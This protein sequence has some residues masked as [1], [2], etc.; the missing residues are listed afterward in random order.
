MVNK[1]VLVVGGGA[2]GLMAAITAAGEGAAVT[3][4]EQ[5]E[6]PGKK[7]CATGNGR[8]NLTNLE[9]PED[10]YRGNHPRFV[11]D[12]LAF[13]SVQ[14]TI[15]F[16]T[17]IGIYPTN[18]NGYLYPHSGQAQSVVDVLCMEASH[19]KVKIKTNAKVTALHYTDGVW[20]IQ[21]EGWTYEADALILANGSC[22]SAIA[23]SDGSGY[24]L[25]KSLGHH[26]Y[27]PLPALVPLKCKGN[28]YAQWA[29]VRTEGKVTLYIDGKPA[30]SAAGEL[31]LTE[32]GISGIPVFQ[33]SRYAVQALQKS[34]K[35]SVSLD[36]LPEFSKEEFVSFM[37]QRRQD[38][39]YKSEKELL[40]GLFP[41]KLIKVLLGQKDLCH[42][43]KGFELQVSGSGSMTQAQVCAGGV[44]TKEVDSTTMESRLCPGLYFAGELLDVDGCCGGYN[45]QW[46]WSSGAMAGFSA[47]RKEKE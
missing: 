16:F 24:E 25:A 20:K 30:A 12:A 28:H 26:V 13:F 6:K 41:D 10:A 19:R 46:A 17:K 15:R 38:C 23:G 3:L 4:L 39:S 29:G 33:I 1:R 44:D 32:Y 11:K 8:C 43:V 31:Q 42:A 21:T 9:M 14:D 40:T 36:F 5:N 34:Q 2:S 22:A 7:I 18:R 37:E 35:A 27:E 47:A 45:L